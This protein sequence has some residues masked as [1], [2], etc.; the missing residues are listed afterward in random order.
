MSS[1]NKNTRIPKETKFRGPPPTTP[2][3]REKGENL[4]AVVI[5]VWNIGYDFLGAGGE[6][7]GY[8]ADTCA[9]KILL[10]MYE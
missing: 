4:E 1:R 6:F 7:E 2:Q 10:L 9:K 8:F 3:K 5:R